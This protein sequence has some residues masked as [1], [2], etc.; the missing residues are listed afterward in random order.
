ME[1][2]TDQGLLLAFV[3]GA[4]IGAGKPQAGPD[5]DGDAFLVRLPGGEARAVA[6]DDADDLVLMLGDGVNQAG[7]RGLRA[8]PHALRVAADPTA[9]SA[10]VWYGRMVL[11]PAGAV[12]PEH[13]ETFGRLRDRLVAATGEEEAEVHALGCSGTGRARQLEETQCMEGS[14]YC[15]HRCMLQ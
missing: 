5:G 9:S 12:H 14:T 2:H 11:P 15:W 10:R 7:L 8:V 6:F 13:G 4:R 3:P 1:W